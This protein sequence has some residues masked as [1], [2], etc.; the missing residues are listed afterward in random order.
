MADWKATRRKLMAG[1]GASALLSL[2][3]RGLAEPG[4]R[5][6]P[7]V[8]F[9]MADDLGFAD[10]SCYGQTAFMTPVLDALAAGGLRFTQGYANSA[11]CS[12]TRTALVTG[13]YQQRFAVGLEEPVG[14]ALDL[15]LPPGTP[16]IASR[17]KALGYRTALAGKW[18]VG[19]IP[20]H[21]PTRFGYDHFFGLSSGSADYFGHA[22][23]P[24]D[25]RSHRAGLFFDETPV[26]REGYLT[27]LL[28][29]EA[30]R[31]IGEGEAPYFLSLHFNAPH[32]PW[33]GPEDRAHSQQLKVLRDP[34]GGSLETYGKMVQA[35][36]RAI[37]HVLEAL[38]K[39]RPGRETIVVFTSDNGGERYSDTWPLTGIKGELLE[40]GIRVPLI[41]HWE[42]RIVPG[43]V[44]DQV[45]TSMDFMPTLLAAAGAP[46]LSAGE[47]DGA[48]LLPQILG[49]APVVPR[50]LFWRYNANDQAAVR[51]GDWKYLKLGGKEHLFNVAA[52]PRERAELAGEHPERFAAL[53]ALYAGWEAQMLPYTPS[54]R[55]E[56]VKQYYP[57]RY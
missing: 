7:D 23:A 31:W 54:N 8:L 21:G 47:T 55:S 25:T 24:A 18:H 10:L 37:G 20:E 49:R 48:N 40:G 36:D 46:P 1:A 12:A 28:A 41:V 35:M 30:A 51:E 19:S 16:T 39:A 44:T 22:G 4:R 27:Y 42:G 45:M 15:G 57:D 2:G 3:T 29:Q 6:A 53:K 52:D 34:S 14:P 26:Q 56:D 17:F 32:W 9:I 11:V 5:Q 43:G 38:A 13:R 33:E 50:T